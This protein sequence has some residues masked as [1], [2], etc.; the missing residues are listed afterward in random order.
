MSYSLFCQINVKNLQRR[1]EQLLEEEELP[2]Q[3]RP[4]PWGDGLLQDLE[5]DCEMEGGPITQLRDT[6]E[7]GAEAYTQYHTAVI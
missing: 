6:L 1:L 2:E 4:P 5:P 7:E 3:E